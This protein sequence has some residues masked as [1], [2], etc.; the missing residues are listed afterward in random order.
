MTDLLTPIQAALDLPHTPPTFTEAGAL[1]STF[2][3]TELAA[4][5]IG[6]AGQAVGVPGEMLAGEA[7]ARVAAVMVQ[8]RLVVPQH[9]GIAFRQRRLLRHHAAPRGTFRQPA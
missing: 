8:H 7:H 4:A 6:A 9:D 2:A 3:V 5:S 1:P